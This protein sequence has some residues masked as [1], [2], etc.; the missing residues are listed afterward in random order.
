MSDRSL[1]RNL[2]VWFAAAVV[3][4]FVTLMISNAFDTPGD[5][6]DSGIAEVMNTIGFFSMLAVLPLLV[7][8][9]V[10]TLLRK[11]RTVA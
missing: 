10:Q 9:V 1:A 11:R 6:N 8:A 4:T 2:W 7:A 3:I 5:N